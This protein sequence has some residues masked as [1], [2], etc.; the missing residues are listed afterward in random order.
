MIRRSEKRN[1]KNDLKSVIE[2]TI[3][4]CLPPHFGQSINSLFSSNEYLLTWE[5]IVFAI[6]KSSLFTKSFTPP[7]AL[8]YNGF[9]STVLLSRIKTS[10]PSDSSFPLKIIASDVY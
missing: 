5:R 7:T 3:F 10:I 4:I 8:L 1:D 6:K 2:V 9:V